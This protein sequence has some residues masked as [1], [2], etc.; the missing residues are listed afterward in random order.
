MKS[1][2]ELEDIAKK[3][4]HNVEMRG[5]KHGVSYYIGMDDCGIKSGARDIMHEFVKVI[6]DLGI[7]DSFVYICECMGECEN[8]PMVKVV[9]LDGQEIL[10]RNVAISMVKDIVK[11]HMK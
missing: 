5:L 10:Y 9:D 1:L 11:K 6:H 7:E 8:E 2:E 4:K 3:L